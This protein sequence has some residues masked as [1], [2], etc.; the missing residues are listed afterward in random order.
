MI[1]TCNKNNYFVFIFIYDGDIWEIILRSARSVA[2][3][4]GVGVF[5]VNYLG[6]L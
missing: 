6:F 5:F 2:T 1:Q 4:G 3:G